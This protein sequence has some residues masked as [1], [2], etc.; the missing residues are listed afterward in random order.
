MSRSPAL[1]EADGVGRRAP[2]GGTWLLRGVSLAVAPGERVAVT[3]PSGAGKSLLLRALALLDP[4]D[5]G[6][7]RWRGDPVAPEAVPEFRSRVQYLHQR[8][9]VFDGSVEANLRRPFELAIHADRSFDR[10]AAASILSELGR[11]PRFLDRDTSDL[12]GG[13]A[14]LVAFLRAVQ[15][16]PD[17][18][19]L[20][21]P[22]TA[23][24]PEATETIER[25]VE[26]WFDGRAGERAFVWVSHDAE[27]SGRMTERALE[28]A[29]G[30][31]RA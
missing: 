1:L 18:L 4:V 11:E 26:R 5:E 24:D 9:A 6:E 8:P 31:V 13:E 16:E 3:G 10:E 27:Q 22:T 21:E 17:A 28:L 14:Q 2:D 12:S 29:G 30:E 15:L 20:D 23:L 7:V 19:L 25:L